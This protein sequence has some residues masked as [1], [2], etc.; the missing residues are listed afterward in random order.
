MGRGNSSWINFAHKNQ[1]GEG[2]LGYVAPDQIE[3]GKFPFAGIDDVCPFRRICRAR[4]SVVKAL[5]TRIGSQRRKP[6]RKRNS[7]SATTQRKERI[8]WSHEIDWLGSITTVN[9]SKLF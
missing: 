2:N 7:T 4:L 3:D 9:G 1:E 5:F 8:L 6:T